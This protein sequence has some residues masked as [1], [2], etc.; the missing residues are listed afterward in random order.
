MKLLLYILLLFPVALSAQQRFYPMVDFYKDRLYHTTYE[1]LPDS[2]YA[3]TYTGASFFPETEETTFQIHHLN[4]DKKE[5]KWLGR[6]L[7]QEHFFEI[8]GNGY[9]ITVNPIVDFSLGRD[10][11]AVTTTNLFCNTRGFEVK[12]DITDKV[13][14]SSDFRE[15]QQR[16]ADYQAHYITQSGEYYPGSGNYIQQNGSVPGAARTKPFKG[17]A[18]DYAYV[19]G[20]VTYR[21]FRFLRVSLGNN[22]HFVG[23]GYRSV[24]LS[25]YSANA[26]YLRFSYRI[27]KKLSGEA[28]YG[29]Q[30]NLLRT[31]IQSNATER[32]YEKKGFSAHYFTYKPWEFAAISFFES[33]VW[34]RGD[35]TEIRRVH[36]LYYNPVPIINTAVLGTKGTRSNSMIGINML[37]KL[38]AH[39]HVYGQLAL[40]DFRSF[41]P[42]YQVG[43][44]WSEPFRIRNLFFQVEYNTVPEGFYTHPNRRLNFSHNN[45]PL[46]HPVGNNFSE[47]IVRLSYEWKRIAIESKTNLYRTKRD[48]NTGML[49]DRLL[50]VSSIPSVI[51][52]GRLFLQQVDVLYRF[53]RMNNLQIFL[54]MLYRK[55]AFPSSDSQTL[56]VGFGLRTQLENR[57]FDF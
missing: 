19:T 57:Y 47:A 30:L 9:F 4:E 50:A 49:G 43:M 11:H 26:P 3:Y 45:L 22:R 32:Q 48:L 51:E 27:N 15:N 20:S 2:V 55:E 1:I 12:G 10:L 44:R 14:F 33:T 5:R 36:G 37:V 42:A 38:P 52:N 17:D 54:S 24:L 39:F 13:S 7:F 53:N 8:K 28:I 6:K 35:S 18:F 40:D 46:V 31:E 29:Q 41:S 56:Y 25:D 34:D 23:S 16:F 21:P